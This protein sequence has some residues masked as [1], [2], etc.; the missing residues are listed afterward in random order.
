MYGATAAS[1]W[2]FLLAF[3]H[4]SEILLLKVSLWSNLTPKILAVITF[5]IKMFYPYIDSIVFAN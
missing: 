5:Y 1:A 3:L 2:T 4:M